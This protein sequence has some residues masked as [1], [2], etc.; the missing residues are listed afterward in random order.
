MPRPASISAQPDLAGR[1]AAGRAGALKAAAAGLLVSVPVTTWWAVGNLSPRVNARLTYDL[2]PYSMDPTVERVLGLSALA[3]TL[4]CATVLTRST[5]RH[6]LAAIW[7]APLTLA[8][9][10][11]VVAAVA[12]R[13]AT[14]GFVGATIGG[15]V[16]AL[17]VG[18]CLAGLLVTAAAVLAVHAARRRP[19]SSGPQQR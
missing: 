3:V 16:F 10:A 11:G 15:G 19:P 2:G 14:A 5:M 6:R 18:A 8:V 7:W 1:G 4:L 9:L 17:M 12:W 13:A